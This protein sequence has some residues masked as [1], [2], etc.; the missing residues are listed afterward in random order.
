LKRRRDINVRG[1]EEKLEAITRTKAKVAAL[2]FIC[3]IVV[4]G[5]QYLD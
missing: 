3:I 1:E 4:K 2:L 5:K